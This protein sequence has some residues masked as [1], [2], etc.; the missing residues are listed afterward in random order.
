MLTVQIIFQQNNP[1]PSLHL[2]LNK[3]QLYLIIQSPQNK[4]KLIIAQLLQILALAFI[5]L[6]KNQN[7]SNF[8]TS[9][10]L[11]LIDKIEFPK[12]NQFSGKAN[13]I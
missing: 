1:N 8:G 6:I 9:Q 3:H 4:S 13:L 5:K 11:F 2:I 7:I 12:S 10:K